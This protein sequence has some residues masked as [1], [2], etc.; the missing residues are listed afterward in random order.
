MTA[1]SLSTIA[2]P[3]EPVKPVSQASRSAQGG[4][5]SFWKRSAR[6]TMRPSRPR[7]ASSARSAATCGAL[8]A[9]S[10]RSWNDWK[11]ASNIGCNLWG[12]DAAGNAG[13]GPGR[14]HEN[15]RGPAVDFDAPFEGKSVVSRN[16]GVRLCRQQAGQDN[17]GTRSGQSGEG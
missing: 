8:A 9:R 7:R 6:G 16:R 12:S 2:T 13:A 10:P 15:E 3:A 17:T 14:A 4:T 1:R 11:W 5:Y